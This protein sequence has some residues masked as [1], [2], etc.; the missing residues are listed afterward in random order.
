MSLEESS[1]LNRSEQQVDRQLVQP[2]VGKRFPGECA[3]IKCMLEQL[4]SVPSRIIF[5]LGKTHA[6]RS[7]LA[8]YLLNLFVLVPEPG[9]LF[10]DEI[11][12]HATT[13]EIF[14]A[15]VIFGAV[16]VRIEMARPLVTNVFQKLHNEKRR[17]QIVGAEPEILIVATAHL[18]IQIKVKQFS[19]V[20]RQCQGVRA[21]QACHVLVGDLGIDSKFFVLIESVDECQIMARRGEID[22]GARLVW[23]G[24]EGEF[25]AVSTIGGVPGH[26]VER[27][28]IVFYGL[29]WIAAGVRLHSIAAAPYHEYFGTQLGAE[30]HR[31]Q[32]FLQ[33]VGADS[34]IIRSVSTVFENRI[35]EGIHG[36]HGHNNV[37]ALARLLETCHNAVALPRGCVNRHQVI[38]MQIHAPSANLREESYDVVGRKR[39]SY[40]IPERIAAAISHSPKAKRK[41]MLLLGLKRVSGHWW[42]PCQT[43]VRSTQRAERCG[44]EAVYVN[45]RAIVPPVFQ[46]ATIGIST[47][48]F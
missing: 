12:P 2:F 16:G 28:P 7:N 5:H 42:D 43:C 47:R 13:R 3:A 26:V 32:N 27:I 33:G 6:R 34:W 39:I 14:Y 36:R 11:G 9:L 35:E 15:L 41:L 10:Q 37:M 29:Q 30:V 45:G 25:I 23:L 48:R 22:I 24:F 20:P 4:G 40:K 44:K 31:T 8:Q 38:V 46:I 19:S 21:I 1:V 18:V 17:L